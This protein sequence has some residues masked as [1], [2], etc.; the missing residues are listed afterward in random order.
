[1]SQKHFTTDQK[2]TNP[3]RK[4]KKPYRTYL[5]LRP[6]GYFFLD[7]CE[8]VPPFDFIGRYRSARSDGPQRG[9]GL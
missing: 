3:N 4:V 8:P 2:S 5:V 6:E 9:T 1:M 7:E